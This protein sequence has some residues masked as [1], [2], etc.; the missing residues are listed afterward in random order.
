MN[1]D[2]R[3]EQ[4]AEVSA[5]E[6][7]KLL[8]DR[9]LCV[10]FEYMVKLLKG[11][12]FIDGSV[13]SDTFEEAIVKYTR[14]ERDI[15][16]A[17]TKRTG[18]H[19]YSEDG[20][21]TEEYDVLVKGIFSEINKDYTQNPDAFPDIH[22]INQVTEDSINALPEG[23]GGENHKDKREKV[24]SVEYS[25]VHGPKGFEEYGISKD[26]DCVELHFIPPAQREDGRTSG[27]LSLRK[28]IEESFGRIARRVK[29]EHLTAKAVTANSWLLDP[30]IKFAQKLGFKGLS[31]YGGTGFIRSNA[32]WG[33]FID[34]NRQ[35]KEGEV[36]KFLETGIPKYRATLGYIPIEEFLEKYGEEKKD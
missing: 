20:K 15:R 36:Q 27:V 13:V 1:P 7:E 19:A 30:K 26:D 22:R 29:E 33:Q 10:Q 4:R 31:Q 9:M 12:P 17:Y 32:F 3:P 24:G 28:N 18:K 2:N 8:R 35:V 16:T 14:L 25:V 5:E 21:H 23:E 11:E 6:R 34:E